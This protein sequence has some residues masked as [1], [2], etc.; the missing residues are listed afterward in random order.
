MLLLSYIIVTTAIVIAS[1]GVY[2]LV[3]SRNL[4]RQL[5]SIEVIFNSVILLMLIFIGGNPHLATMIAIIL[6][7]V[8]AGEVVIVMALILS[9]YRSV[10]TLLS[11]PLEEPGV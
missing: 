2:G 5:L 6:V 7:S 3:A 4:I 11:D 9:M 1:I 10:K 8:V